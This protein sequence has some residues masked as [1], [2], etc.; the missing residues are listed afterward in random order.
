MTTSIH[1]TNTDSST[2]DNDFN[3]SLID[4]DN[5]ERRRPERA[6]Y[7]PPAT[8]PFN[9]KLHNQ[10]TTTTRTMSTSDELSNVHPSTSYNVSQSHQQRFSTSNR[11]RYVSRSLNNRANFRVNNY[12]KRTRMFSVAQSKIEKS[13]VNRQQPKQQEPKKD[14]SQGKSIQQQQNLN[15]KESLQIPN[16]QQAPAEQVPKQESHSQQQK[17]PQLQLHPK[18]EQKPKQEQSRQI[19]N[20]SQK[21]VQQQKCQQE[22]ESKKEN[23][24]GT[25]SQKQ[26]KNQQQEQKAKQVKTQLMSKKSRQVQK[27]QLIQPK[28]HQNVIVSYYQSQDEQQGKIDLNNW[29]ESIKSKTVVEKV[30][31]AA[32]AAAAAKTVPNNKSPQC[33]KMNEPKPRPNDLNLNSKQAASLMNTKVTLPNVRQDNSWDYVCIG[34]ESNQTKKSNEQTRENKVI[35]DHHKVL[36]WS[37]CP[38]TSSAASTSA[39]KQQ[40]HLYPNPNPNIMNRSNYRNNNMNK[41]LQINQSTPSNERFNIDI[42]ASTINIRKNGRSNRSG[43]IEINL[44]QLNL[45]D[46]KPSY[47]GGRPFQRNYHHHYHQKQQQQQPQQQK[48]QSQTVS[49]YYQS[50]KTSTNVIEQQLC[51]K[52]QQPK[53]QQQQEKAEKKLPCETRPTSLPKAGLLRLN[54]ELMRLMK[55]ANHIPIESDHDQQQQKPQQQP[56]PQ[57]QLQKSQMVET[58]FDDKKLN[59]EQAQNLHTKLDYAI[60][61]STK[62]LNH[63]DPMIKTLREKVIHS[64][65]E[66]IL[67]DMNMARINDTLPSLWQICF[68]EFIDHYRQN[69]RVEF[70]R[71]TRWDDKRTIDL[72]NQ[73]IDDGEMFFESL[74]NKVK[75]DYNVTYYTLVERRKHYDLNRS[76]Y[77]LLQE[78]TYCMKI[79]YIYLGDLS[80]YRQTIQTKPNFEQAKSFYMK[81]HMLVPKNA[82]ACSQ[83]A[84]I[85]YF[86]KNH[87]DAVYYFIRSFETEGSSIEVNANNNRNSVFS[88]WHSYFVPGSSRHEHKQI[89]TVIFDDI[90]HC[91]DDDHRSLMKE[92]QTVMERSKCER[93]RSRRINKNYRIEYWIGPERIAKCDMYNFYDLARIGS[94]QTDPDLFRY[95]CEQLLPKYTCRDLEKRFIF[96][97]LMVHGMLNCR[98]GLDRFFDVSNQML[99]EFES[100]IY[101]RYS[102]NDQTS[103]DKVDCHNLSSV[104]MIQLLVINI[105]SISNTITDDDRTKNSAFYTFPH[106]NSYFIM[107][108]MM[109]IIIERLIELFDVF[110]CKH[111]QFSNEFSEKESVKETGWDINEETTSQPLVDD[112]PNIE[113]LFK[114]NESIEENGSESI[115]DWKDFY[116]LLP[117]VK[118][119]ADWVISAR[120]RLPPQEM[121]DLNTRVDQNVWQVFA[122]F[123]SLIDQIKTYPVN[124]YSEEKSPLSLAP[125]KNVSFFKNEYELVQ[126][127]EDRCLEGFKLILNAPESSKYIKLP[128]IPEI[129][130]TYMRIASIQLFGDYLCGMNQPYLKYNSKRGQFE[131]AIEL[132]DIEGQPV[133]LIV[134]RELEQIK[135]RGKRLNNESIDDRDVA[136]SELANEILC[137]IRHVL[138]LKCSN[139]RS[140]TSKGSLLDSIDLQ[141]D[142]DNPNAYNNDDYVLYSCLNLIKDDHKNPTNEQMIS[143]LKD[144]GE[145]VSDK[146]EYIYRNVV[147]ITNDLNLRLKSLCF[148]VPVRKLKQFRQWTIKFG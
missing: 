56:Q 54:Q 45:D 19:P 18:Q 21:Q 15:Q 13:I 127:P 5:L 144:A 110:K 115:Q 1:L 75:T 20:Q 30:D 114:D 124:F 95:Y 53:I 97:F 80:R 102:Q 64:Y 55:Q 113:D 52:S 112:E 93:E 132:D 101:H 135:A 89:L 6:L 87:F 47:S 126:L 61:T 106:M 103:T 40:Y 35:I 136:K 129:A 66:I 118:I 42:N 123:L 34:G 69:L 60:R 41:S 143:Q 51:E 71:N 26:I 58:S 3:R 140:V 8:R 77:A 138:S 31:A 91:Y 70:E 98:I 81:A 133:P 44:A 147:L 131:S 79:I 49:Y 116:Q 11:S 63:T 12:G 4:I 82:H 14:E 74:A 68:Y 88:S 23:S 9:R 57:P 32:A 85:C 84:M 33:I 48:Q 37:P 25:S 72:L 96:S 105:Y 125:P 59:L 2:D 111:Q 139:L 90:H 146:D 137:W 134:V 94:K 10:R 73:I 109:I 46:T 128:F 36:N 117:C 78:I 107:S 121:N 65:E 62:P 108:S 99:A 83:I 130:F 76:L 145:S 120:P 67:N 22:P 7:R 92:Y 24:Q 119:W 28:Q 148:E 29:F 27:K 142:F 39:Q 141:E 17:Q 38:S 50:N 43:L 86:Q 16:Q 100:L 122:K 104:R